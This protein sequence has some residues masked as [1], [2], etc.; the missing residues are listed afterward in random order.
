MAPQLAASASAGVK[1]SAA[2]LLVV[3]PDDVVLRAAQ[4]CVLPLGHV[5]VLA[6]SLRQAK[7][8]LTRVHVDLIC[9]DS[10]LPDRELE[11]FWRWLLA[12]REQ[13]PPPVLFLAPASAKLAPAALPAFF[14]PQRDGL[15]SK[16]LEGS[17]MAREVARLLS[18]RSRKRRKADLL[19]AGSLTLDGVTQQLYFASGG[20]LCLT[21]TEFRL[22]RYLM[23]RPGEFVSPE[24]LLEQVWGYVPGTGGAEVVRSHIS[25][26]RRKLRAMGEDPQTLRTIPY[27]GYGLADGE[28][29]ASLS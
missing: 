16:P 9:L 3:S 13:Q 17:E 20:A 19:R 7:R 22:L 2:Q 29:A 1:G 5:P 23:Q 26:L 28:G 21:P 8:A 6:R 10:I 12:G 27:R 14:Q 18:G 11:R 4:H 24:E 15:V 25:N